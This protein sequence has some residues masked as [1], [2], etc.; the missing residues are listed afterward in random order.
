MND[1]WVEN[2]FRPTRALIGSK[3]EHEKRTIQRIKAPVQQRQHLLTNERWTFELIAL[4][5]D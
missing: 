1:W 2:V 4:A 3:R 5:W